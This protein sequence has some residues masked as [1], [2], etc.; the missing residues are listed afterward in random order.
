MDWLILFKGM[1]VGV[2]VAAPVGPVGVLCIHR[3][4]TAGWNAGI[5]LGL[6]A[7]TADALFAGIAAFSVA[8]VSGFFTD[9]QAWLQI[10]G[11]IVLLAFGAHALRRPPGGKAQPNTIQ[12]VVGNFTTT[13]VLTLTNPLTLFAFTGMFALF[14]LTEVYSRFGDAASLVAGIFLGSMLW[15]IFLSSSTLF[16]KSRVNALPMKWIH[17]V[18]GIVLIACGLFALG[19]GLS[20]YFFR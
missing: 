10:I 5:I 1:V 13:L 15:W 11:G 18:V 4:L 6:G 19:K 20:D 17:R 2:A 16:M 7:A 3:S 9:H 12:T 14:G 8:A